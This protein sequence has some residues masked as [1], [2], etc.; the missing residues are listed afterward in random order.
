MIATKDEK[1]L[2]ATA[3]VQVK[4]RNGDRI[5]LRTVVDQGSQGAMVTE[6]AL[7][8]LNVPVEKVMAGIDGLAGV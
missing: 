2:L 4:A 3:I 7:Q 8:K 1:N 6:S 5:M